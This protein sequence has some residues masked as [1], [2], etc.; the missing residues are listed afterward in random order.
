MDKVCSNVQSLTILCR[1]HRLVCSTWFAGDLSTLSLGMCHPR[2]FRHL[3]E[4]RS[5][6]SRLPNSLPP[7]NLEY[8]IIFFHAEKMHTGRLYGTAMVRTPMV[9]PGLP[10]LAILHHGS[11]SINYCP[12]HLQESEYIFSYSSLMFSSKFSFMFSLVYLYIYYPP[13]P[14]LCISSLRHH[15]PFSPHVWTISIYLSYIHHWLVPPQPRLWVIHCES[16]LS[17]TH[18]TSISSFSYL[19]TP[20]WIQAL[21]SDAMF[22]HTDILQSRHILQIK[23]CFNR[24]TDIT[25]IIIGWNLRKL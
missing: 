10:G 18:H 7:P 16:Y 11:F 6:T 12:L 22:Q 19:L 3:L 17:V 21:V 25:M 4:S 24:G 15:P 23:I 14:S 5:C 9:Y 13:T 1:S 2:T 8:N 20:A